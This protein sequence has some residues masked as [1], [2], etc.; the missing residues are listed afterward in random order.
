MANLDMTG[1]PSSQQWAP[2]GEI[3]ALFHKLHVDVLCNLSFLKWK[4]LSEGIKIH[5]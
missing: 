2:D 5:V 1:M 3:N 4:M